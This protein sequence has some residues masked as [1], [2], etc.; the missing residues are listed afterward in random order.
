MSDDF[1][2]DLLSGH[3]PR[4]RHG[5]R[6]A[7][8]RLQ[9]TVAA[10]AMALVL[11]TAMAAVALVEAS[12]ARSTA[13]AFTE[14]PDLS[15]TVAG[16]SQTTGTPSGTTPVAGAAEPT[17]QTAA[18]TAL[19]RIPAGAADGKLLANVSVD[20]AGRLLAIY[21]DGSSRVVGQ[22]Q[23]KLNSPLLTGL[24][25]VNGHLIASFTNGQ[26][27][28]LGQIVGPPGARGPAGPS[29]APGPTVTVTNGPSGPP[30]PSGPAGPAGRRGPRGPSGAPGP[31]GPS[32]PAGD[33]GRG[34]ASI[35]CTGS[36]VSLTIT[37][38]DGTHDTVSCSG[39]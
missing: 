5:E 31:S 17:A 6:R 8:R 10:L 26:K 38:S 1:R 27:S 22:V 21:Q 37:Y 33:D 11:V 14:T 36:G 30:G 18:A 28:D 39:G 2:T 13:A 20:P 24:A 35:T 3:S 29:G 7:V 9:W 4:G 25:V 34:I 19:P 23:P 16:T 15:P 12:S 32:G